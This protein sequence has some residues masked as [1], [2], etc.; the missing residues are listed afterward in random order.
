MSPRIR[1]QATLR[2]RA[3]ASAAGGR[4]VAAPASDAPTGAPDAPGRPATNREQSLR[5][6][7]LAYQANPEA[8]TLKERLAELGQIL[9]AGAR[10]LRLSLEASGPLERD[11]PA[12]ERTP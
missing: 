8:M 7:A 5:S 10:R 1:V 9:A 11:C 3:G 6:G 2:S 4:A 12:M